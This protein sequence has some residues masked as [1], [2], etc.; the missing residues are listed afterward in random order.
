MPRDIPVELVKIS[1]DLLLEDILK[2]VNKCM[3]DEDDIPKNWRYEL[4][5][6][7]GK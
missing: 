4:H 2:A 3:I 5:T 6:Q 7:E 1:P